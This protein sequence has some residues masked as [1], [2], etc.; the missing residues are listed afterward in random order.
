[1]DV[2]L[3]KTEKGDIFLDVGAHIG[4][5]ALQ[6][7]KIVGEKGLV[8][9]IEPMPENYDALLQNIWLN[10]LENIIPLNIAAW[11]TESDLKLFIG[12]KNGR[13]SLK[14]N[15]GLGYVEVKTKVLDKV[16]K[17]LNVNQVDWI[18][19]DV[20]G[21]E[22]EVLQGLGNTLKNNRPKLIVEVKNEN[23]HRVINL[24]KK[25]NYNVHP[26]DA[27]DNEYYYF[28]PNLHS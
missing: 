15:R 27:S 2:A 16:L 19:I 22:Y 26:I 13:N 14:N 9:A 12:D 25:L 28:K 5:Y 1:M 21:A 7:A 17:K 3:P 20:E 24:M 8:I 11:N 10:K 6:V 18:K 4:K 23:K